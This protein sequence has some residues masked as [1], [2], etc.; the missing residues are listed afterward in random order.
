MTSFSVNLALPAIPDVNHPELFQEALKIYNAIRSLAVGLDDYTGGGEINIELQI[1]SDR[2]RTEIQALREEIA[3]LKNLIAT[4]SLKV[5][6][7][8]PGV[9]GDTTP[10]QVIAT[11]L[12]SDSADLGTTST[13]AFG[14]NGMTPVGSYIFP[15]ASTDPDSARALTNHIRAA[16]I[17]CG[18]GS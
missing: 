14:A 2:S 1:N 7:G 12:K 6:W 3:E 9:I 18:I 15:A 8:Q 10:D 4:T 11:Q 13:G 5:N 16:L 17:L